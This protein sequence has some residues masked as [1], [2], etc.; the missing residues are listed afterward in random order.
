MQGTPHNVL[1]CANSNTAC[2]EIT[3][4]LL[5]VLHRDEILR[6]YAQSYDE[7]NLSAD[8]I[9]ICNLRGGKFEI[10]SLCY[11][12]QHRVVICTLTTAGCMTRARHRDRNFDSEHFGY[13]FIDEAASVHETVSWIAIA[14]VYPF[15]FVFLKKSK[16]GY[17][18]RED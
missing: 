8:I 1:I 14:G 13:I 2:D 3:K 10:P 15:I 11:V 7:K 12:N 6:I 18:H 5:S 17:F 16:F 4:R 9:P